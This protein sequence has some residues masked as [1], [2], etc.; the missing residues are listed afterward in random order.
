MSESSSIIEKDAMMSQMRTT[1]TLDPDTEALVKRLMT[2]RG[3]SFKQAVNRAIRSGLA[4]GSDPPAFSTPSY[5]M[6]AHPQVDLGKVLRLAGDLEN[7]EIAH[8]LA[9]RK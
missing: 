3:I 8:R 6:G 5:P 4:P 7:E 2:E 1:V 9:A